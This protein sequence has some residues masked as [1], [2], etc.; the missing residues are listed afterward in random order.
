M[1]IKRVFVSAT[2]FLA[3]LF[4]GSKSHAWIWEQAPDKTMTVVYST[5][6]AVNLTTTTILVDLSDTTNWPH[7]ETGQINLSGIRVD[8]D[9][10]ADSSATVKVGLVTFVNTSTG[11][12]TWVHISGRSKNVSNTGADATQTFGPYFAKLK[13]NESV[14]T[15][16][17]TNRADGVTPFIIASET[18]KTLGST[19]YQKDVVLPTLRSTQVAP[20]LG[21]VILE[22]TNHAGIGSASTLNVRVELQ[23]HTER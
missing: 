6:A 16:A 19:L 22:L 14:A 5:A 12:V 15:A 17:G 10:P 7:K 18:S 23:Y 4:M 3:A 20:G 1:T 2:I 9:K 21:D 8:F 13:V 11:N